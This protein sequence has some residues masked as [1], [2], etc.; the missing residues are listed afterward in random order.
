MVP[1]IASGVMISPIASGIS[2]TN[3]TD[4]R[5]TNVLLALVRTVLRPRRAE[6]NHR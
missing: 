1:M 3:N 5:R 2:S 6:V 4:L